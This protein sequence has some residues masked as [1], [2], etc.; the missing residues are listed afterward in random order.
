MAAASVSTDPPSSAIMLRNGGFATLIVLTLTWAICAAFKPH[1]LTTWVGFSFMA[2]TPAQIILA[3]L[4]KTNHPPAIAR[5][6]QPRKGILLTAAT[7]LTACVIGPLLFYL[8]GGGVGPPTPMLLMFTMTTIIATMWLVSVWSCWPVS[9]LTSNRTALGVVTLVAAYAVA[10]LVF[11]LLFDFSFLAHTPL[12]V[13]SLDPKGRLDAWVALSFL[14]TTVAVIVVASAFDFWPV[15]ALIRSRRQPA[16]GLASTILILAASIL[17]YLSFTRLVGFDPVQHLVR[18]AVSLI[19]GIFLVQIMMR[20]QLFA[21]WRQPLR[22]VAL[23]AIAGLLA[24]LMYSLYAISASVISA[25][26]VPAGPPAYELEI[27]VANAMLGITFPLMIVVADFFELWPLN[28][29][30]NLNHR[31]PGD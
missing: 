27:W 4:W 10:F 17:L 11:N 24:L 22:G 29:P 16:F 9:M 6:S 8:G 15:S 25:R 14:V 30:P 26:T 23:T 20:H 2:A 3:L 12:Y 1:V 31:A 19:Y 5:L 7:V 28:R 21:G 13:A 18:V